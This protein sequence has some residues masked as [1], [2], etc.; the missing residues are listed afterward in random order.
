[1][2]DLTGLTARAVPSIRAGC[3]SHT[4]VAIRACWR[5]AAHPPQ[6]WLP[7]RHGSKRVVCCRRDCS[8]GRRT[9]AEPTPHAALAL[10]AKQQPA[11][12]GS[13]LKSTVLGLARRSPGWRPSHRRGTRRSRVHCARMPHRLTWTISP[14]HE[15][16][17]RRCGSRPAQRHVPCRFTLRPRIAGVQLRWTPKR[18]SSQWRSSRNARPLVGMCQRWE[19]RV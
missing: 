9:E 6:A 10:R 11:G 12:G 18:A 8:I 5:Y 15:I 3:R 19:A 17:G 7:H 1:V 4:R 13:A 16:V 14:E 2:P